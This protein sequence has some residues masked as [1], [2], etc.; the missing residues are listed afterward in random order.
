MRSD[1]FADG[2]HYACTIPLTTLL[3]HTPA[4]LIASVTVYRSAL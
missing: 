1:V 3:R 2:R 4:G